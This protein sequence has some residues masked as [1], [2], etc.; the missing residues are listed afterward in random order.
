MSTQTLITQTID[1]GLNYKGMWTIK[2]MNGSI[3]ELTHHILMNNF[4]FHFPYYFAQN[5][6]LDL[7]FA[8]HKSLLVNLVSSVQ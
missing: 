1:L 7:S 3:S 4:M 6:F 8:S 2:I 5:R